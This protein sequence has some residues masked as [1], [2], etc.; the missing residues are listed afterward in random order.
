MLGRI[1]LDKAVRWPPSRIPGVAA[2]M[3]TRQNSPQHG[4]ARKTACA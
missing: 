3:P 1:R 2:E 4:A